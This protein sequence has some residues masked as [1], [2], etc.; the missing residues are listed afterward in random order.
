MTL[1]LEDEFNLSKTMQIVSIRKGKNWQFKLSIN[2]T[3]IEPSTP[4]INLE[5]MS[6][7]H[8]KN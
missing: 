4:N 1:I 7:K 3:I 2:D 8:F 5:K 6:K